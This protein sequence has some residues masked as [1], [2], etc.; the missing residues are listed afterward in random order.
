MRRPRSPLE[1]LVTALF[2]VSVVGI[3]VTIVAFDA[4]T[5]PSGS[6]EPRLNVDDRVLARTVFVDPGVGDI[7]VYE[8]TINE[9]ASARVSRVVAVGGTTV[10]GRDGRLLRDGEPVDE[11]Y[12]ADGTRTPDFP[13]VALANDELFVLGDNRGNSGDSRIDGPLDTDAVV[14]EVAFTNRPLDAIAIGAAAGSGLVLLA[15]LLR[16]REPRA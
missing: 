15:L 11:P 13:E 14:A 9:A 7:V 4:Y 16:R 10:E 8:G 2:V 1:L 12:L 6:M 5:I 3:G